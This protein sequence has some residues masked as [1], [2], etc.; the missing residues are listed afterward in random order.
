MIEIDSL[1]KLHER[2]RSKKKQIKLFQ[3]QHANQRPEQVTK[4]AIEFVLNCFTSQLNHRI[5]VSNKC[6]IYGFACVS[7]PKITA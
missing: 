6:T 5:S 2:I 7:K 1:Y 3:G 4:E